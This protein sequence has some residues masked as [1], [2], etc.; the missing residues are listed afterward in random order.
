MAK[1]RNCNLRRPRGRA[2]ASSRRRNW[3]DGLAVDGSLKAVVVVVVVVVVEAAETS[4]SSEIG[5]GD[6]A[7]LRSHRGFLEDATAL[8][9]SYD[10][11]C[12]SWKYHNWPD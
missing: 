12:P 8:I 7:D 5:L 4:S 10:R 11:S 1:H 2:E 6:F 3:K 9:P